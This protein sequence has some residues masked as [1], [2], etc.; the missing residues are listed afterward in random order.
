MAKVF[1][2][3]TLRMIT[4]REF[5]TMVTGEPLLSWSVEELLVMSIGS[6]F[7]PVKRF[8]VGR[9]GAKAWVHQGE[10]SVSH[11]G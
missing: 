11:A 2:I 6:R 1:P 3:E 4:P 7:W 5:R 9:Y 8:R 10:R